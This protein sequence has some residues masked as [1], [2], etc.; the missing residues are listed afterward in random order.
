VAGDFNDNL[1]DKN[2]AVN[3]FMSELGMREIMIEFNGSGPA[4]HIRGSSKIDGVYATYGIQAT[5]TG[6][7]SFEQSPSDHRWLIVDIH[8]GNLIGTPRDD[9][10]PPLMRKCTSKIPSVKDKFQST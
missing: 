1:N 7:T 9:K 4:T 3:R 5:Y 10:K 6:Y 8:E 2:N